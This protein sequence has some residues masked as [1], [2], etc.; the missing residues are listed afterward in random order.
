MQ[1]SDI[2]SI[3]VKNEQIFQEIFHAGKGKVVL[4][5]MFMKF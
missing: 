5:C 1:I 4:L 3:M 2:T